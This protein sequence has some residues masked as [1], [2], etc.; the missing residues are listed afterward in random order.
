MAELP[1]LNAQLR[2][3]SGA[4][5]DAI[6]GRWF[7]EETER[8][9]NLYRRD[10]ARLVLW[11]PAGLALLYGAVLGPHGLLAWASAPPAYGATAMYL[12]GPGRPWVLIAGLGL[13]LAWAGKAFGAFRH[14]RA[15]RKVAEDDCPLPSADL[16]PKLWDELGHRPAGLEG[17]RETEGSDGERAL[18]NLLAK[19]LDDD[20]VCLVGPLVAESLDVDLLVLG[21]TGLWVLDSKYH[22]GR[23]DY[24][25]GQFV[26]TKTLGDRTVEKEF[27]IVGE[28]DREVG[29]V[30]AA[31]TE[32]GL[33]PLQAQVRGIVAFTHPEIRLHTLGAPFP[34]LLPRQVPSVILKAPRVRGINA[35]AI[36]RVVDALAHQ[37]VRLATNDADG[38]K[39]SARDWLR[40]EARHR[41]LEIADC[42]T[43]YGRGGQG[44]G[45][46][47][48]PAG[49]GAP[50][51][52]RH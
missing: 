21:P 27:D 35:D 39:V 17:L 15:R 46:E 25:G 50:R 45:R 24:V 2:S 20:H 8:R 51:R 6:R 36:F 14:A 37:A 32:P 38:V 43:R 40:E 28:I 7:A 3:K 30:R 18:A 10:R 22:R 9:K 13:A 33:V 44:R 34:C 16:M 12:A 48:D 49:G 4:K 26:K 31:L 5:L 23:V 47:P 41:E 11:M 1:R 19:A 52:R 29:G 42:I